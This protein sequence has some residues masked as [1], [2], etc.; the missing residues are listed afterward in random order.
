MNFIY[1]TA[2]TARQHSPTGLPGWSTV[3]GWPIHWSCYGISASKYFMF[4]KSLNANQRKCEI[5]L[6]VA[7][8]LEYKIPFIAISLR[9]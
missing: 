8:K 6:K 5:K 4:I 9:G 1:K 2:R 7:D 3:Y